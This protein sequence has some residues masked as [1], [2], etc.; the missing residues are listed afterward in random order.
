MTELREALAL[1]LGL[2][3]ASP[4]LALDETFNVPTRTVSDED[5]LR[6][7]DNAG[8]PVTITGQLSGPDS[9]EPVPVV[10]LLHGSGGPKSGAIGAWRY[11]LNGLGITTLRLDSFTARGIDE[12]S[13][14]P[15]AAIGLFTQLYDAYRAAGALATDPRIDGSHIAFLGSSLGGVA[16]LY[17]AMTR[18]EEAFGAK[19]AT[20][21]ARV[22][23]YPLCN[24]EL[25]GE[26]DVVDGPIRVFHGAEDD[27]APVAPC[28]DYI[29]RLRA[30]G[31]DAAI[32]VYP[33]AL[34]NFDNVSGPALNTYPEGVTTRNCMRREENGQLI[35]VDTGRPFS[36][37]DACVENGPTTQYNDAASTAAQE[38]VQSLLKD[39]FDLS[40]AP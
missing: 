18:F 14:G 22:A 37:Q 36:Y 19:D 35:N 7:D 38:A 40:A 16:S 28:Q 23:F 12:V 13:T 20:I 6:G 11:Y 25:Q 27:W 1:G 34:H 3:C 15:A 26:L 30:V 29:K 5:F 17:S 32:T 24:F 10:I 31:A 9:T 39:V 8:V 2:L 33:D 4:A 21:V